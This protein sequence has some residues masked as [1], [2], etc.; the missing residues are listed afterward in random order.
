MAGKKSLKQ[1]ESNTHKG[2]NI[3]PMN[4]LFLYF[5]LIAITFLFGGL[6]AAFF[7]SGLQKG[8]QKFSLPSIF[9]ANTVIIIASSLTLHFALLSLK[10]DDLVNYL[11]GLGITFLLGVS[12]IIFQV[13]GWYELHINGIKINSLPTGSY[14]YMISGLHALHF[15]P[16][17]VVLGISF[18]KALR[19]NYDPVA[20]LLFTADPVKK[21]NVSLVALYWHFVDVL[22]LFIYLLFVLNLYFP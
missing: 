3:L 11:Y 10:K 12:F 2:G 9:H 18:F 20:E 16:G 1:I 21:N 17:I 22:W 19:R 15:I 7:Y 5:A 8:F 13:L 4:K 14:L 6:I